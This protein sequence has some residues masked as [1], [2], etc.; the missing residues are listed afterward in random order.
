MAQQKT[1]LVINDISCVGKCSLTVSLPVLSAAGVETSVLPTAVL[2]THTGGFGTPVFR[3]LT[4]DMAPTAAHWRSQGVAFDALYA[5]YL[6]SAEQVS[7]VS[8]LLDQFGGSAL[9]LV[10]PVMGDNGRL[11]SGFDADFPQKLLPL[12]ARADVLVPN[13]TEAALLLG[14]D[15]LPPPYTRDYVEG[16]LRR[17]SALCPGQLVLT[18]VSLSEDDLG[19]AV[20]HPAEDRVEYVLFPR[21]PGHFHGTGDLFASA[22]LAGLLAER[23]LADCAALAA[24]FTARSIRLTPPD[25]EERLGVCF[26]RALPWL[27]EQLNLV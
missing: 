23:P 11:Y 1:A 25:R 20:Y 12:C 6:G 22:L 16:L 5:G 4:G 10:D 8:E 18:G 13:V 17:L 3:D 15:Y 26:E 19:C 27:M 14:E 24:Q 21:V 7:I 9:K 2:S